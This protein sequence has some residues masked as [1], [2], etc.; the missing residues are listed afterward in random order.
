MPLWAKILAAVVFTA[1]MAVLSAIVHAVVP[2]F[3]AWLTQSLG[4]TGAWVAIILVLLACG[5]YGI[6][7]HRKAGTRPN[8]R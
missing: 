4:E 1:V 7:D 2:G 8:G 3:D 5:A 6:Y